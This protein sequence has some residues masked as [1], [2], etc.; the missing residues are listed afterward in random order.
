MTSQDLLALWR[1]VGA[2]LAVVTP[3]GWG[4]LGA[5][6]LLAL[7]GR[8]A[9]WVEA[10]VLALAGALLVLLSVLLTL[11]GV[12]LDLR[13][14]LLPPRVRAGRT[15]Y[16]RLHVTNP[17]PTSSRTATVEM[18]VGPDLAQFRLPRLGPGEQTM[19][20]FDIP[21]TRRAVIPVG[22]VVTVRAD[23]I[24]LCRREVSGSELAELFV[25]PV[26]VALPSLDAGLVRDLEGRP[27]QDPSAADLDFHTLRTY[28]P[29]DDR[30]HIHWSSSARVSAMRGATTLMMKSYTDT[31]RSHLGVLLDGRLDSYLDE[32]AFEDAV[33]VAASIASRAQRDEMDVSV[34]AAHQVMDRVG[35]IRTLDGFSRVTPS[36]ADLASLGSHLVTLA[37]AMSIAVLV[38]GSENAF[39]DIQRAFAQFGPQVRTHV[40]RVRPGETSSTT[41]VHGCT[42]LTMGQLSDLPRLISVAGLA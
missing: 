30:R 8:A 28:A 24:G 5:A 31:R 9:G 29:G 21:T 6:L 25:H 36:S 17:R 22:P 16:G 2:R 1:P 34:V 27:T 20:E 7:V 11:G 23:P 40:V 13:V 14:E 37:P 10:L 41:T 18:P 12:A 33:V 39:R 35:E 4:F 19:F 32:E 3:L 38:T 15:A 42:V 26:L